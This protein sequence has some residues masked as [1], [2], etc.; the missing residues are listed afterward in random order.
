M[1]LSSLIDETCLCSTF[2]SSLDTLLS[3]MMFYFL[4][5]VKHQNLKMLDD[6]VSTI[7]WLHTDIP[8]PDSDLLSIEISFGRCQRS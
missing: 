8:N 3:K 5:F 2:W 1:T 4:L 6:F 7:I